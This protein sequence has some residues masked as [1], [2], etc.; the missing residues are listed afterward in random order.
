MDGRE[1]EPPKRRKYTHSPSVGQAP[2]HGDTADSSGT[3]TINM[4]KITNNT[5][6]V[7]NVYYTRAD[8]N[9]WDSQNNRHADDQWTG[10][11]QE[12][13]VWRHQ[14]QQTAQWQSQRNSDGQWQTTGWREETNQWST[15]HNYHPNNYWHSSWNVQTPWI[16]D[17]YTDWNDDA[18]IN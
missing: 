4:T 2:I 6:H 5:T 3:T 16:D 11:H 9:W 17:R 7:T 12:Q 8:S 15:D 18:E 13:H 14:S 1:Y 10:H